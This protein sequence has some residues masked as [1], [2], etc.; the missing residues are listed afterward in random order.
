LRRERDRRAHCPTYPVR[1][2]AATCC[3]AAMRTQGSK[4]YHPRRASRTPV[5]R[6]RV[7]CKESPKARRPVR[8]QRMKTGGSDTSARTDFHPYEQQTT[9]SSQRVLLRSIPSRR[10]QLLSCSPGV[11][12]DMA[13]KLHRSMLLGGRPTPSAPSRRD[14]PSRWSPPQETSCP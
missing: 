9:Q 14:R 5:H 6:G 3:C 11:C 12:A 7:G 2:R 4:L 8:M 10:R 1:C 13:K